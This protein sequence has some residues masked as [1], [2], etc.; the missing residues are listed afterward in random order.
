MTNETLP[1]MTV[2]AAQT[3]GGPAEEY[4]LL[5]ANVAQNA[6][7]VMLSDTTYISENRIS[8]KMR[9]VF[10]L[11]DVWLAAGDHIAVWT[12]HGT[13]GFYTGAN[14]NTLPGHRIYHHYLN[15]SSSIW[16]D[17][18]DRATLF[19]LDQ[20]TTSVVHGRSL[21]KAA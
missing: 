13:P 9:H 10:L 6:K 1:P 5:R 18:K 8:N 21:K 4:V 11:P 20:W 14:A 15:L 3:I 12:G 19:F 17:Q 7:F 2:A 16:N